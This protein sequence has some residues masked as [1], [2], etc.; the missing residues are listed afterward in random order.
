MSDGIDA[1]TRKLAA[2][3][4]GE[5]STDN[6]SNEIGGIAFAVANRARAWGHKT[7]EELLTADKNYTYAVSDG[8][9][10]YGKLMEATDAEIIADKNGM[11]IAVDWAKKALANEGDDP[12]NGAYWWDGVDFKTNSNHPKRK[13][14][15]C[16]GETSHNIFSIDEKKVTTTTYWTIRNNKTGEE[17]KKVRGTYDYVWKSTAAHGKTI[18]WRY[19]P[20]FIKASG[21]KEYR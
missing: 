1:Q 4:F 21:A 18:F 6:V 14:G 9:A 20:D 11:A 2:I 5:A 13:D 10:R 19:H 16:Y 3:A 8:N 15:F 17:T 12:S 7:V